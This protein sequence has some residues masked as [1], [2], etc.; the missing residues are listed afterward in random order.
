MGGPNPKGRGSQ[1]VVSSRKTG[2]TQGPRSRGSDCS[3]QM[4]M[5]WNDGATVWQALYIYI[6][7]QLPSNTPRFVFVSPFYRKKL[8][9]GTKIVQLVRYRSRIQTQT[10][11]T[12]DPVR[13]LTLQKLVQA[14]GA[15]SRLVWGPLGRPL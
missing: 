11:V 15:Q 7:S 13:V 5:R 6:I 4:G 9:V 1:W 14:L 10:E 8:R 3:H 12:P 2:R